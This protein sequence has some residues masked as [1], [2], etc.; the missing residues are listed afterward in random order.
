LPRYYEPLRRPTRPGLALASFRLA[1]THRHRWGFPCCAALR[2]QACRRP[3]PGGPPDGIGSLPR[4]PPRPPSLFFRQ[5][6]SR[7]TRF[8][9]GS[10]FP[11]VTAGLPAR[12]PEATPPSE[13]FGSFVTSTAAPIATGRSESCRVG[14]A[15][16]EELPLCT[17]H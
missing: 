2:V 15:P 16:T 17:A 8:G 7:I 6:R 14:V 9:P 12:S 1:V 11:H 3:Y 10:A 4:C 5:V 13:G